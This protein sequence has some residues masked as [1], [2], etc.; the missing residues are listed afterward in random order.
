MRSLS[1]T[2]K[3]GAS[4]QSVFYPRVSEPFKRRLCGVLGFGTS[5]ESG[6]VEFWV[7]GGSVFAFPT[8]MAHGVNGW[9][10]TGGVLFPT[11]CCP[12]P[13]PAL[14]SHGPAG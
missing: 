9:P 6:T 14:H 13:R 7:P 4:D 1:A 5:S 2:A 3:Q 8:V 10:G 11:S 12:S